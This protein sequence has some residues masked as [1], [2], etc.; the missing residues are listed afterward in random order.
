LKNV[1]KNYLE[2]YYFSNGIYFEGSLKNG[3]KKYGVIIDSKKMMLLYEGPFDS[4]GCFFAGTVIKFMKGNTL[5]V[6]KDKDGNKQLV[7]TDK[8]GNEHIGTYDEGD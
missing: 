4:D 6:K 8:E 3:L 5:E 1:R 2:R 7:H